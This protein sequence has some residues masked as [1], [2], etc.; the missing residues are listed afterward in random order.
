MIAGSR[1]PTVSSSSR[2][3]SLA[4]AADRIS[5]PQR[6]R[7]TRVSRFCPVPARSP[8]AQLVIQAALFCPGTQARMSDSGHESTGAP[9]R[10]MLRGSA[11]RPRRECYHEKAIRLSRGRLPTARLNSMDNAVGP[12]RRV[13]R[14]V[15]DRGAWSACRA[16]PCDLCL[17]RPRRR[18]CAIPTGCV[19]EPRPGAVAEK[20]WDRPLVICL[21]T[22][23]VQVARTALES[24]RRLD[25]AGATRWP[26]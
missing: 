23:L 9:P 13:I 16:I 1:P 12:A 18:F 25:S 17:L 10:Q 19:A 15:R 20:C 21:S 6:S 4:K 26:A 8:G 24:T 5:S 3:G 7:P 14:W 2:F 11:H 22:H